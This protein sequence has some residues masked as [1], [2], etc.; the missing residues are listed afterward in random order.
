[1]VVGAPHVDGVFSVEPKDDPILVVDANRV[2]T[3]QLI[4]QSV[5]P[6]PRRNS[7]RVELVTESI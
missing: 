2:E 4:D 1:V 3:G 5:E 7:Q 6:I